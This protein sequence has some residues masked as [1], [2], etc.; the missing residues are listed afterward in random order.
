MFHAYRRGQNMAWQRWLLYAARVASGPELVQVL[1]R[2]SQLI[3]GYVDQALGRVMAEAQRE[4]EEVLG[5]ALAR[6]T[7]RSA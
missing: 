6:R 2:S 5:G 4:R 7:G 1:E 3:F